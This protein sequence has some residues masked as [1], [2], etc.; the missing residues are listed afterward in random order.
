MIRPVFIAAMLLVP[1]LCL[2][3]PR[4]ARDPDWPCQ[5]IKV[6]E[7]S[8]AAVWSGPAV[9]PGDTAW[10][11]NP[12]VVDLVE[13]LAPR[14]EP[15]DHAQSLVHDF[16]QHAGDQKQTQLLQVLVGLFNVLNQERD[17]VMTGLDR[18]GGRQK[19]LAAEIRSD[20]EKLRGLQ[21]DSTSD[22]KTVQQMTQKVTWEAEVFQDRRQALSYTCDV[23]GKIEQRLFALARQIQQELG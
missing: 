3:Q 2:A 8:I 11:D 21:T 6:P 10:K 12:S 19:E 15:I 22:P 18:F 13:K 17:S 16:A 14:R 20:N 5:Q 23:P 7:L 1:T 4:G 9:D